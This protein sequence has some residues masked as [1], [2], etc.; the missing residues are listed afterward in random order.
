MKNNQVPIELVSYIQNEH[1]LKVFQIEEQ[2]VTSLGISRNL[3]VVPKVSSDI[4][5]AMEK[6]HE[7]DLVSLEEI[8]E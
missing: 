2:L 1:Y 3:G 4:I 8:E 5:S 6:L 7:D